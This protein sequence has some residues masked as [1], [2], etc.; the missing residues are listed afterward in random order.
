MPATAAENLDISDPK[1]D[2]TTPGKEGSPHFLR[3][4]VLCATVAL[5]DGYDTQAIAFAG[6]VIAPLWGVKT[7]AFGPVFSAALLGL[8]IGSTLFG[9]AADRWGRKPIICIAAAIFGLFSLL[10]ATSST[11]GELLLWRFLTGIGLGAAIPN[12]IALTAEH[13]PERHRALALG[14]MFCGFPAGALMCGLAAPAM[15]EAGGWE[16]I[17]VIGGIFPL[18]LAPILWWALKESP[19]WLSNRGLAKPNLV[20]VGQLFSKEFRGLSALLWL[21]FF[22][23]LFALYFLINWMPSV[24][25][26]AGLSFEA[27]SQTTVILNVGGIA[28]GLLINPLIDRFGAFRILPVTF[29]F[30]GIAVALVGQ[31]EPASALLLPA[32]FCAGIGV[33][34]GQLG[35]N[36]FAAAAYPALL[37]ASGVGW[38]LSV[39]RIGAVAGPAIGG[40]LLARGVG[41]EG[42]FLA[43]AASTLVPTA[44]F[45]LLGRKSPSSKELPT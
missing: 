8:M 40:I 14:V 32:I 11:M 9:A 45:L 25:T 43:A 20:P 1:V 41:L 35:G 26:E 23:N 17:F 27:A 21:A 2:R 34:G 42:L 18:I 24:F 28:G 22:A 33:I 15:V 5:L 3:V 6:P 16:L 37:R 4:L 12:L 31:I 10:T 19:D 7:N 36:A 30:A 38:A 29:G 13:A 39:G 44:V